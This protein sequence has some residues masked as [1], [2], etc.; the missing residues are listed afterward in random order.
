[1]SK[2]GTVTDATPAA[3]LGRPAPG[4]VGPG[5]G[6]RAT[7]AAGVDSGPSLL[8]VAVTVAVTALASA[9]ATVWGTY[10]VTT[11]QER[12][13]RR[14][15]LLADVL[16]AAVKAVIVTHFR[17]LH[18]EW[19]PQDPDDPLRDALER[20]RRHAAAAGPDDWIR[21]AEV[22]FRYE[23]ASVR[24]SGAVL[25]E[26]SEEASA[27]AR[28]AALGDTR[29]IVGLLRDYE[30]WVERRLATPPWWRRLPRLR[31]LSPDEGATR[32]RR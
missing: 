16:P 25:P 24:A 13:G 29:R 30:E 26:T 28:R 1:M 18:G 23:A 14:A 8:V 15:A 11:T 31:V 2:V 32:R 3:G 21:V 10:L 17:I 5:S 9:L 20:V 22:R 19:N 7:Y 27:A 4:A 12:R 6:T